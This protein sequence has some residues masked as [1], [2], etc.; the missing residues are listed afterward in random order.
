MP[1]GMGHL[2]LWV[3]SDLQLPEE[4]VGRICAKRT[5]KQRTQGEESVI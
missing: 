5:E 3:L 4:R 2:S 1:E